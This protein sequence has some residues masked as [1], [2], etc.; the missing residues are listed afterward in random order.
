MLDASY[1][2]LKIEPLVER[3][4]ITLDPKLLDG[5]VGAYRLGPYTLI[6][7]SREGDHLYTQL[8]GQPKIEVF[9]ESE[10]KFFLKAVDAQLTFD[11][12]QNGAATQVT[13]HQ[14]GRDIVAKRLDETATKR[15]LEEI[16]AHDAA[17]AKRIQE[18]TPS[19]SP[20]TEAALRRVIQEL[21]IGK[22]NYDLMDPQ[23]AALT[24]QQLP[25]LMAM[26]S[27]FGALQSVTFKGVAQSGADI[28]EV[29]FEHGA[30]EWRISLGPD[31][32]IQGIGVR[33]L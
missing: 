9:A 27:Q 15:A 8:T 25:Q 6:T 12:D 29:K 1:P 3:K 2:L 16:A 22:P 14:N 32:K 24:R 19:P 28:F 7:M 20:G 26:I 21:Q 17:T 5:Y 31:G 4:E 23:F 11:V 10:R 18:R 30:T 13:L 33:P